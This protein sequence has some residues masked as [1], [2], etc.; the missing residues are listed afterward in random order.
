MTDS[1]AL[2]PARIKE[3]RRET[4]K[5]IQML[6]TLPTLPAVAMRVIS[7]ARE[8]D[9]EISELKKII[10]TDAPLA[11]R[12]MKVANSALYSRRYPANTLEQCIM[13]IG[14][15]SV[16][17]V[18]VSTGMMQA[19]D[20]W[21]SRL[22]DRSTLW[23]HSLATGF[24]ARSLESRKQVRENPGIDMFLAGLLHNI[25]WMVI[26]HLFHDTMRQLLAIREE[27]DHWDRRYEIEEL[28]M[29]HAAVG[30]YFLYLW[31]IDEQICKVIRF[32]HTPEGAEELALYSAILE[33]A[34][35]LSPYAFLMEEPFVQVSS[36]LPHMLDETTG[37]EAL[38]EMQKRYE[39]HV[40]MAKKMVDLMSV[41]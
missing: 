18:C 23:K 29:D 4:I 12:I 28:G 13:T 19:L 26:D 3:L 35:F 11:A 7:I 22:L 2:D 31:G 33:T 38:N 25:G 32:H 1:G 6:D 9:A 34:T 14:L 17:E 21:E 10:Q 40:H 24:L 16:I 37:L 20:E 41:F 39:S 30:A 5:A 15:N 36:H 8:A 27:V